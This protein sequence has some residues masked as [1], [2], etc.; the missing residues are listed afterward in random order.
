MEAS[1]D[2]RRVETHLMPHQKECSPTVKSLRNAIEQERAQL[3]TELEQTAREPSG[4]ASR[5][6]RLGRIYRAFFQYT[7]ATGTG[8]R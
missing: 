8:G 1:L 6:G 3:R 4:D 7:G 2:R 5:G